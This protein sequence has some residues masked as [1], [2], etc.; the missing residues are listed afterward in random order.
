MRSAILILAS[1]LLGAPAGAEQAIVFAVNKENPV[2]ELTVN[3]VSDYYFKRRTRWADGAKIQF[4][5]QRDGSARKE[6]FL[7]LIGRT[8]RDLD[9][10]WIG[11][12]NFSGQ[13]APLQAP[14]DT[15]VLSMVGS[16]AGG[17]GYVSADKAAT[18][19]VK[20]ITVKKSE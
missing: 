20:L 18:D 12:K 7:T 3:D 19:K 10:F 8:Q 1:F 17:I 9:L 13:S 11:E 14:S 4:I 2:T 15:M 5:D 16:L 6:S